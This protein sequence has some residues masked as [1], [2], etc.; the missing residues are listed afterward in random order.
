M[1]RKNGSDKRKKAPDDLDAFHLSYKL[2]SS[3]DRTY[4]MYP[5]VNTVNAMPGDYAFVLRYFDTSPATRAMTPVT[6]GERSRRPR[7]IES[8]S[9]LKMRTA[10]PKRQKND[11]RRFTNCSFMFFLLL[12]NPTEDVDG[13]AEPVPESPRPR[14]HRVVLE[15]LAL[16]WPMVEAGIIRGDHVVIEEDPCVAYLRA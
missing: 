14:R 11:L 15:E 5:L 16:V 13:E 9:R 7:F 2:R 12:D 10:I 6:A 8:H 1:D 4:S 3:P